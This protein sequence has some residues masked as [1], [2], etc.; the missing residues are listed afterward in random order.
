MKWSEKASWRRWHLGWALTD[1]G[2]TWGMQEEMNSRE[3]AQRK[4]RLWVGN[5]LGTFEDYRENQGGRRGVS[6]GQG[7]QT[8][9]MLGLVDWTL[10]RCSAVPPEEQYDWIPGAS[11]KHLL[12]VRHCWRHPELIGEQNRET[13]LPSCSVIWFANWK[14]KRE[15][16]TA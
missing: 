15:R 8:Q 10:S 7:G 9:V 3:R 16:E 13:P 2:Q 14:K 4:Q 6:K 12:Y 5:E 11:T 1:R